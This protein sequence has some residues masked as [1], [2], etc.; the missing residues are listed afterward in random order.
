MQRGEMGPHVALLWRKHLN[1]LITAHFSVRPPREY[2]QQQAAA[3]MENQV[4]ALIVHYLLSAP[5]VE[6]PIGPKQAGQPGRS[7]FKA[8]LPGG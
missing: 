8:A 7:D 2:F 6:Q 1:S 3:V 4:G 5:P